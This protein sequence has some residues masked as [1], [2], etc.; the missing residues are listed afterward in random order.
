MKFKNYLEKIC[1]DGNVGSLWAEQ[2]FMHAQLI[3]N[4]TYSSR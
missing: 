3:S 2:R 1:K 4:K